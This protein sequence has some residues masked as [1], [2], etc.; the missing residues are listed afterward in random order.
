MGCKKAAEAY[1]CPYTL[2]LVERLKSKWLVWN[3]WLEAED[4]GR[5]KAILSKEVRG[6]WTL[7]VSP[8]EEK[9]CFLVSAVT[10]VEG[11]GRVRDEE[12]R[13]DCRVVFTAHFWHCVLAVI[14]TNSVQN[15]SDY[16]RNSSEY[17]L[18]N[19]KYIFFLLQS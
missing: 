11:V 6:Q 3:T 8:Q 5:A 9:E 14:R 1:S 12:G 7:M 16:A 10:E 4:A 17:R 2:Y 15:K 19:Y 13:D 18:N